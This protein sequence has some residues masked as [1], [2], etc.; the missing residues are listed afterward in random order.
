MCV[1]VCVC[2]CA[3]VCVLFYP[4]KI[5]ILFHFLCIWVLFQNMSLHF[6]HCLVWAF[7]W[8]APYLFSFIRTL[9]QQPM[10]N[11]VASL[12]HTISTH[13]GDITSLAFTQ[14]KLCHH[15][16]G[17]NCSTV[18]HRWLHRAPL[19][20]TPRTFLHCTLLHLLS[21]WDHLGNLLN[22]WEVDIMGCEDG[23]GQGAVPAC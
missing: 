22:G 19:L 13:T 11:M 4:I 7:V 10:A 20:S 21:L 5:S 9:R 23:R 14:G 1:C 18:E 3:C 17:Q 6:L 15:F 2:V 16:W 12:I 8:R